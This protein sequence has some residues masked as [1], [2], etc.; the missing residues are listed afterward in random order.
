MPDGLEQAAFPVEA[1][2]CNLASGQRGRGPGRRQ[3]EIAVQIGALATE[4]ERLI[5]SLLRNGDRLAADGIA[6]P[7]PGRYRHVLREAVMAEML[8]QGD[9]P[10][11]EALMDVMLDGREARRV[12]VA[13][14]NLLALPARIFEGGRLLGSAGERVAALHRL[15]PEED[16]ELHLA[17]RNPASFVPAVWE[18][19]KVRGFEAWMSGVDPRDIVW[20]DVVS[21]LRQ[22]A[23]DMPLIVWCNEDS[24]LIW[25]EL[26]CRLAGLPPST[27]L[28]GRW[29]LMA[30]I[31]PPE[32][33]ERFERYMAL[34]PGHS[35]E[36]ER[37]IMGAFL[38]K[39][40]LPEETWDEVDLPGWDH[41]LVAD[42]TQA[43]EADLARIAAI[44]G[45]TLVRP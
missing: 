17:L 21:A 11:R 5:K 38:D 24:P 14:G 27:L 42:L 28:E 4:G 32:G 3:M 9:P 36:Q 13:I 23:P 10:A 35:P 6:V 12:V 33:M 37:R 2:P 22:A 19:A 44:G 25:G 34:H 1:G 16:I 30:A 7:G 45:V 43:Y 29:D 39:Y 20:S 41:G 18:Q 8:G 15:F 40:A 26:M 31:M